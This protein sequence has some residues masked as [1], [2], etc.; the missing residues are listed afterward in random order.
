M[1]TA[2]YW[3]CFARC[4][5]GACLAAAVASAYAQQS[6]PTRPVRIIVPSSAG[7]GTDT[8]TRLVSNKLGEFLGQR[9]VIENR[10][11]AASIVGSEI[12]A[13][14]AP[15]GYTLLAAISTITINPSVHK[16]LPYDAI[17][18]FAPISQFIWLPNVPVGHPS[19]PPETLKGL[20]GFIKARPGELQFASNA[21][22]ISAYFFTRSRIA[23][24]SA[25]ASGPQ[26]A[27]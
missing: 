1:K 16:S 10:A 26:G 6:Y 5:L 21:G 3:S 20:I 13:R 24:K 4:V 27:L 18:D 7:G 25:F 9:V 17:R 19:I 22:P 23:A 14:S 8:T 2:Y 11:G 15:D 12:V